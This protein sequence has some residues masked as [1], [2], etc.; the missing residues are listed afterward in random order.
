LTESETEDNDCEISTSDVKWKHAIVKDLVS[1]KTNDKK[2]VRRHSISQCELETTK[3]AAES[4]TDI[5]A[6]SSITAVP[7]S[8]SRQMHVTTLN[9]NLSEV[10]HIRS[11]LVRA[12]LEA[13]P[14]DESVK[15]SIEQGKT[16]IV[17]TNTRF[18]MFRRGDKCEVCL[19]TVCYKCFT[20]MR[21]PAEQFSTIPV[22]VLSPS[23][24]KNTS[25]LV[26]TCLVPKFHTNKSNCAGSAPNSPQ[27]IK[28][29]LSETLSSSKILNEQLQS[30]P[31]LNSYPIPSISPPLVTSK[32]FTL[33]RKKMDGRSKI[34]T[35]EN[36][37]EKLEGSLLTVCT[38]CSEMVKQVIR[39][40]GENKRI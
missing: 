38:A 4:E 39:S 19:Q 12:E 30:L 21:I 18:G 7:S 31:T 5:P 6:Y 23:S 17:C 16:C 36:D 11:V 20:K 34:S 32:Y 40:R 14:L 37:R 26:P 13:L 27:L 1:M 8:P 33:P 25:S 3:Q 28:K 35:R 2:L 22:E 9:L 15:Q 10:K 29:N 24:C